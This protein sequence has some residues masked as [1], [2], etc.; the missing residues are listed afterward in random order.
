MMSVTDKAK[1]QGEIHQMQ[2]KLE[3]T[4]DSFSYNKGPVND[5]LRIVI[6]MMQDQLKIL[7]TILDAL[8]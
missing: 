2:K 5:A 4:Q 8:H 7:R 6:P 1:I 3:E